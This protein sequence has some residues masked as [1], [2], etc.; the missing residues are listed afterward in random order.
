VQDLDFSSEYSLVAYK[1]DY[2]HA[3]AGWFETHFSFGKQKINLSTSMELKGTHWKQSVFYL[4]DE[5]A[6]KKGEKITGSI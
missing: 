4:D 1:T 6:I 2:I 5:I 3:L